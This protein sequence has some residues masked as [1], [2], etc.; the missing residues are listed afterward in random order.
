MRADHSAIRPLRERTRLLAGATYFKGLEAALLKN[1]L[2]PSLHSH[3]QANEIH[4]SLLYLENEVVIP[5]HKR[6]LNMFLTSYN[7]NHLVL[8]DFPVILLIVAETFKG[9]NS[10]I[11]TLVLLS[12]WII[13]VSLA[14]IQLTHTEAK[15]T[16]QTW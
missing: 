5:L 2:E 4:R 7:M 15:V 13:D 9:I 16:M 8:I 3:E 1:S 10:I 14:I 11:V 12:I 6:I